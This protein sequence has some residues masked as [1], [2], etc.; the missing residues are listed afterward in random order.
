MVK[1][2]EKV[3][4]YSETSQTT[5]SLLSQIAKLHLKFYFSHD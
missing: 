2:S 3:H 4:R 1:D 5:K